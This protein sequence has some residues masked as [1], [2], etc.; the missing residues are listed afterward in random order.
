M[1]DGKI[2]MS[3]DVH[4]GDPRAMWDE[5]ARD[6][7]IVTLGQRIVARKDLTI[8][9]E[10]THMEIKQTFDELLRKVILQGGAISADEQLQTLLGA[11]PAK[12]DVCRE[13]NFARDPQPDIHYVWDKMFDIETTEKR[14]AP[15][16]G[17]LAM[18]TEAYYQTS[19]GRG[20]L[21][22][23]ERGCRGEGGTRGGGKKKLF[24]MW[25]VGSVEH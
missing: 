6:Y 4:N 7:D 5:L 12:N 10:S 20:S 17:A 21:R 19:R 18:A 2:I 25:R 11:I 22:G 1:V 13:K 3:L 8:S 23:R 16:S 24:Y 15:H 14:R 9:V